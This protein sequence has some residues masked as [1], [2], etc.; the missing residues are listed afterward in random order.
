[1]PGSQVRV[2]SGV[3]RSQTR[4]TEASNLHV[5]FDAWLYQGFD[6]AR[7]ALMEAISARLVEAVAEDSPLRDKVK[8]FAKRVHYFRVL[9]LGMDLAATAM[10]APTRGAFTAGGGNAD[11]GSGNT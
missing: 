7:A 4:A 5:E 11:P 10:G 2:L 1:M 9:G 3:P 8:K 6:D